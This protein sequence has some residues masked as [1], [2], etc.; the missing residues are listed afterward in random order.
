MEIEI[1][2]RPAYS[3]GVIRLGG[4]E[5]VRVEGG[6]MVGMSAGMTLETGATGGILRSLGRALLGERASSRT[7]TGRR[8][9]EAR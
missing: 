2:Y 3:L 8:A 5:E 9:R 4:G 1:L 6:S 7:P